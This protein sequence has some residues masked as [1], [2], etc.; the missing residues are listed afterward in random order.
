VK[1]ILI[2]TNY[3]PPES[4][5]AA[6]RIEQLAVQLKVNGYKVS[7][8]SPMPNYP[9]G[10]IFERYK[11]K[12]FK[13]ELRHGIHVNRLWI[14]PSNSKKVWDRLLSTA[15]FASVLVLRL[16]FGR[17]PEKVVV[18]SPPLLLSFLATIALGIRR[19]KIILNVSDLWPL[20]AIELGALEPGTRKHRIALYMERFI[21]RRAHVILGQSQEILDHI[22]T[23]VPGKECHLYRNIPLSNRKFR[24]AKGEPSIKLFYAGLLGV[25]Q[26]VLECIRRMDFYGTNVEFHIFGDGAEKT[27]IREYI[28][29][30][31]EKN[32]A[33]H[34]MVERKILLDML[35]KYDIAFVP[36][37]TRIYGSVP[38]KIFEYSALGMPVLYFGGG[39]GESIVNDYNLGFV[40]PV[41]DYDALN[42][43]IQQISTNGKQALIDSRAAV[44]ESFD[45]NFSLEKQMTD[46]IEKGVF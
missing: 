18:Q 44:K 31:P 39:E 6:N 3:Y 41:G 42:A 34:G 12:Y 46:L 40:A 28:V 16:L 22:Q 26:G 1:K 24:F 30:N 20:A 19:R 38:S 5:A 43:L 37:A 14:Y 35:Q 25:A 36:L 45:K 7:V 9:E 29:A 11:G 32:I 33:Y 10:K 21:Y 23:V 17:L 8:L 15:S 27:K 4:G 13:K 2:V